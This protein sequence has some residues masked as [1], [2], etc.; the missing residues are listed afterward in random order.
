MGHSVWDQHEK[1]T[2]V[3]DF[4][5]I[6]YIHSKCGDMKSQQILY[7]HSKC[8]DMKSQQFL[9]AQVIWLLGNE[10]AKLLLSEDF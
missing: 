9:G 7:I 8:G 10:M 1:L 3:S 6:L 4:S 2:H 5:Q